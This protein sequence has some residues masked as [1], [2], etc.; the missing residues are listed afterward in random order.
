M[1]EKTEYL[2]ILIDYSRDELIPEQGMSMLTRKGFYKKDG[3]QS[4]QEGF[5]RAAVCYSFGDYGLAQ[6]VYDYVSLKH[7]VN[8]S[9]VLSNALPVKWPV[10]SVDQFQEA[11]DWLEANVEPDGMPISCFL[12]KVSDSK[13]S[14]VETRSETAWLSMLGGGIG[15]WFANRSPDEKSTGVMAHAAGYDADTL[16]YKQKESRRGSQAAYLDVD[17][18]EIM[19]FIDMRNPVGGDSNK[20]CFNLNNAV[21]ITDK[22]MHDMIKGNEYELVDPKHGGTGRFLKAREVWEKIL[23]M[24][25]ETG[26]PYIMWKD[27]V[28]RAKPSWI[29]NPMY[30]VG[31]SNLCSEI[32]LWTSEKRTAV[33]CL[34]SLNLE[35]YEEWKDTQ[36]VEDM[37][38][39]LD[40]VLEYFIRLAPPEMAK[41]VYS[42]K[43]ERAL[44]LGTLGWHSYLQSKMIPF[45]SGGFNSAVQH[46]HTIYGNLKSRGIKASQQLAL[47]RGEAPDCVGSGMRNSHLFAIAPNAS[48]SSKV[49]VSP[50]V[51]P[52]K[53]NCFVADGRAGSYLIKNKWLQKVLDMRGEDTEEVWKSIENND[54][55]VQ[56]LNC[57][58]EEEKKVFKT[59][60]EISPMWIVEL[61]AARTPYICQ[62]TSL[63]LFGT[64]DIT[65]E[66]MSDI[67][68][69]AWAKKVKSLY[70]FRA[71]GVENAK[72]GTGGSQPLNSVQVRKK[73][74]YEPGCLG[75][76]G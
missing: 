21:V 54:G 63:N 29:R 19:Q 8:A 58:S 43:K 2:G 51:E 24:R 50:S 67:H 25:F 7:Y 31:Q 30:T 47:E 73:I 52:W 34:S 39:F 65:R 36:I 64:K 15:V 62:S 60:R 48:S 66:E 33:C 23:Q 35:T 20:K 13:Q 22:F 69:A 46:T 14:L 74:E 26:E 55:S 56:H 44:G 70:Y 28:N 1:T 57:L 45:E 10:F 68:V 71:E 49:N 3:E 18:P 4:P 53:D 11:G 27:T 40:N 37:I 9:P 42:A 59:S 76:D 5:A 6:R 38:K 12:S 75:C 32:M 41:A 17:H 72:V 16:A 61:A